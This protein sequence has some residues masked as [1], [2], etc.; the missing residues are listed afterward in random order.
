MASEVFST[1]ATTLAATPEAVTALV[2]VKVDTIVRAT[3]RVGEETTLPTTTEKGTPSSARAVR[4]RNST[5][6]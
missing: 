2:V 6:T 5:R 1:I 3:P 4:A